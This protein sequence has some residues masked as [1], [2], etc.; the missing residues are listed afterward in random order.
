MLYIPNDNNFSKYKTKF[1]DY[2][3]SKSGVRYGNFYRVD[4][5]NFEAVFASAA[6]YSAAS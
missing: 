1:D 2:K 4:S 3:S 6:A 5:P